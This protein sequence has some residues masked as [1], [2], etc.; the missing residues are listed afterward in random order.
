M[1]DKS[2]I[3]IEDALKRALGDTTFLQM[4]YDEFIEMLPDFLDW[5]QKAIEDSNADSLDKT[6]HQMKGAAANL[7]ILSIASAAFELEK[8]GKNGDLSVAPNAFEHLKLSIDDFKNQ[9]DLINWAALE[10]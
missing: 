2:I 8:I 5:I 6:A 4:M 1:L 9:L 7:G 3:D 10:G